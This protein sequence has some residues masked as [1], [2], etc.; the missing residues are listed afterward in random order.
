MKFVADLHLHS[1]YSRACSKDLNFPNL[2]KW[3]KYK[4]IDLLSTTDFTHP[5]WF[6]EIKSNLK[7]EG[8][9]LFSYEETKYI[10]GTEVACI[11]S[12]EGKLHRIHIL[13]FVPKLEDV[14][15]INEKLANYGTLPSDGRPMLGISAKNLASIV[16]EINKEVIIIPAHVWTP[17][18]SLYGSNSGFDS[19]EECFGETA[20]YIYA[21][22]TG[23]SSDP[24]MNWRIEDLDNKSIVSFSDA[25]SLP[26]MGR[27]ATVFE[28]S[29]ISYESIYKAIAGPAGL[30]PSPTTSSYPGNTPK[31]AFT[32]EFF[33]E[34]GKYHFS[35]HRNCGIKQSDEETANSGIIC[36][37]CKKKLTLGVMHRVNSLAKR[38]IKYLQIEI[39]S[40]GFVKS[41]LLVNRPPFV[42]LVPLQEIIAESLHVSSLS[43]KVRQEYLNLVKHFG[44]EL[45]VLLKAEI[46][47]I[48]KVAGVA[49]IAQGVQKIRER[50]LVI[51]PGFDGVYGV[52]KIWPGGLQKPKIETQA[53]G[54]IRLFD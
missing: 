15:K 8:N 53:D 25:H 52:V 26:K 3:A 50:D 4:G 23:L 2:S 38:T 40:S 51:E 21:V 48:V 44:S 45:N 37:S 28:A 29:E 19:L 5:S 7:E 20:K 35:G 9:G 41:K 11:Y 42:N 16:L 47:E 12:Q 17:W 36:P 27:E 49:N 43:E 32:I 54:Q 34:E 24:A 22:E 18:F 10:L 30:H 39:E 14:S 46:S 33:P 1:S 6:K 31:I 13:L